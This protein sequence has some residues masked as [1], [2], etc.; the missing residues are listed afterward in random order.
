MGNKSHRRKSLT[1]SGC[2]N[3]CHSGGD[4]ADSHHEDNEE[5]F[6]ISQTT[7]LPATKKI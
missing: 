6:V 7:A 3:F 2:Q 4:A 5:S 1:S